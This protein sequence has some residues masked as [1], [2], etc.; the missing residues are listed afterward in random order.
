MIFVTQVSQM[1]R[2]CGDSKVRGSVLEPVLLDE[3]IDRLVSAAVKQKRLF[4]E[5]KLCFVHKLEIV[6]VP[7]N[8][9]KLSTNI[10]SMC[11]LKHSKAPLTHTH[12]RTHQKNKD[13]GLR[14]K[15]TEQRS[16]SIFCLYIVSDHHS[17]LMIH[18]TD[19]NVIKCDDSYSPRLLHIH[20]VFLFSQCST[21]DQSFFPPPPSSGVAGWY[22]SF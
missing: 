21:N 15:D 20:V 18:F 8:Y 1:V 7:V 4:L 10:F 11:V 17:L 3:I 2:F 19:N 12:A 13:W 22:L 14:V 6:L 5:Y 16:L 9:Q